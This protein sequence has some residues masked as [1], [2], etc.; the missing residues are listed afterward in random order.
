MT[1]ANED[2]LS[3]QNALIKESR[4]KIQALS[5]RIN[6]PVAIIGMGCRVPG[7]DN[8]E[9]LWELLK[10]ERE[11]VSDVPLERWDLDAYYAQEPGTPFKTYARRA[12]YLSNVDLFDAR[13]FG[14]SPREAQQM[15]PQQRLLLEVSYQA[16]EHAKVPADSL[17]DEAVGVFI[18]IS[19]SEYGAMTF[20]EDRLVSQDAY[21]ITGTSLNS[22]AGRLAY[23]YGFH[24]PALAIDTACSSSLVSIYQACRSLINLECHTALAGGVNTLL[25]PGPSIALAQNKV[26]SAS[27]RCSPFGSEADG[28]VRGEGCGVLVLKR[29]ADALTENC[30]I[31]AVIRAGHVNQDGASSGLTVPNG[32][33]QQSLITQAV[34]NAR[35]KPDDIRYVETHGTGTVLGD[36]IEARALQQALCEGQDRQSPLL[37][38]S[39]KANIGHLEAASGVAGVMKVVLAMQ[40][41]YLPAQIHVKE[42]TSLIEWSRDMDVVHEAVPVTYGP[43]APYFAGVSSFGFSGTNAHLIIQDPC[44]AVPEPK[45]AEVK[46]ATTTAHFL[47]VSAKDSTALKALLQRYREYFAQEKEWAE[48]CEA[49]NAGRSHYPY[50]AG[51]VTRDRADLITQLDTACQN[52]CASELPDAA[53]VAWMFTGQGSQ[54]VQMG[55]VLFDTQPAFRLWLEQGD[56]AIAKYLGRSI[57]SVMW[58]EAGMLNSTQYAQPAIFCLQYALA[59]FM[60]SL[61]GQPQ[62]V[63]GHSIGEYAAAVVAGV[64]DLDDAARMIVAR[65]RL[66][67]ERCA[68]GGMLVVFAD[69]QQVDALLRDS[70]TGAEVGVAVINGPCN[71]VLSG[72]PEAIAR[73]AQLAQ[74]YELR[75]VPLAV[76]HAFHSSMMTPMLGEFEEVVKQTRFSRPNIGFISTALGRFADGE[77]VDPAYWVTQVCNAVLFDQAVAAL[78]AE[79]NWAAAPARVCVELGPDKQ[80]VNM[81][82]SLS[83]V[84]AA[85]WLNV[86]Q[87]GDDLTAFAETVRCLY[88]L[89]LPLQWPRRAP[90]GTAILPL[91]GY[92]FSRQR[93]WLAGMSGGSA[94]NRALDYEVEW[95]EV[96]Q[97]PLAGALQGLQGHW[98]LLI[99]DDELADSLSQVMIEAGAKVSVVAPATLDTNQIFDTLLQ[100]EIEAVIFY[101]PERGISD[102][103]ESASVFNA[104]NIITRIFPQT[105]SAAPRLFCV[106]DSCSTGYRPLASSIAGLCRTVRE[107]ESLAI[108]LIGLDDSMQ[109]AL[110]ATAL[111]DEIRKDRDHEWERRIVGAQVLAPRLRVLSA[112]EN[113]A[114]QSA[115]KIDVVRGD[116]S[117]LIT[118]QCA[119]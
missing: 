84:S 94:S 44:S 59:Q 13:F 114:E 77:L 56:K 55:R 43:D 15:D 40:H 118:S 76:S 85:H 104:L 75:C 31:L 91:P 98:L 11:A 105:D 36:P 117:Y 80:L 16:L 17:R 107:E 65:G 90:N 35:L 73:L 19:S 102:R 71:H 9:A 22:A 49:L 96:S 101:A 25:T 78:D 5:A 81:A 111:V 34:S 52:P 29:L 42:R 88:L 2:L 79:V 50:R 93:F 89:G 20:A 92:P 39:I 48:A 51:F 37:I 41:R 68:P 86:L 97:S 63:L 54:Y 26:L 30:Q 4:E 74:T 99:D 14:I 28:L 87:R 61:T 112:G 38:G 108:T 21:S 119:P 116:R 100:T 72:K 46:P 18:G 82:K 23:Y 62:F 109:A 7:A 53:L 32:Y 45:A 64:F 58:Q 83:V 12:G 70:R 103:P 69:R 115:V 10:N 95:L 8:V 33:A 66:M 106:V 60:S 67:V 57:L 47:G 3:R 24:G 1:Q 27:G 113:T 6:Q 110:R